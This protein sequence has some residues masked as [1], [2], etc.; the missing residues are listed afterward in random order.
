MHLLADQ[1]D[2]VSVW[3]ADERAFGKA[4]V[5]F[6]HHEVRLDDRYQDQHPRPPERSAR[7]EER[8]LAV[9]A[10]LHPEH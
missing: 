9:D 1:Q 2:V 8:S 4:G 3:I 5:P 6:R 7:L 10:L